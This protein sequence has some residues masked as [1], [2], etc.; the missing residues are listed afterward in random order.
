MQSTDMLS[1]LVAAVTDTEA[2]ELA[3]VRALLAPDIHAVGLMLSGSSVDE[4]MAAIESPPSPALAFADWGDPVETEDG[5]TVTG[6]MPPGLPISN[7]ILTIRVGNDRISS[8]VQEVVEV[9]LPATVGIDISGAP[10]EF[11]DSAFERKAPLALAYI[12][13]DGAP[14]MSYRG[15]VQA[16][17][18]NQLAMW[19]RTRAGGFL[20][21][22]ESDPRVTFI[23]A[24]HAKGAH[25][26]FEGRA[27]IES[28]P[29]VRRRV[30]EAS[31][32][33]ERKVD[34]GMRGVAVII[35][36][37]RVQGG[38]LGAAI[39]QRRAD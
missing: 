15:S 34:A 36:L 33:H 18:T 17:G 14:K 7:V 38:P 27:R 29:E 28:D 8:I 13:P 23:G 9:G 24:D 1:A 35:E 6:D 26:L 22:I 2:D 30:Y 11:V 32:E 39:H 25:Y 21:A 12:G 31:A 37:D 3:A 10:A 4:V 19:N 5:A 20:G 16:F